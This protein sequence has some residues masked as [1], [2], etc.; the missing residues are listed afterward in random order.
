MRVVRKSDHEYIVDSFRCEKCKEWKDHT[1][2]HFGKQYLGSRYKKSAWCKECIISVGLN[3]KWYVKC[4]PRADIDYHTNCDL[5]VC[6]EKP[7][8]N[9]LSLA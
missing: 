2:Y 4:W 1:H 9:T 3:R 7:L 8:L 5:S 6:K